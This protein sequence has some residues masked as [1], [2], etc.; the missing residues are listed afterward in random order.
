MCNMS[1]CTRFVLAFLFGIWSVSGVLAICQKVQTNVKSTRGLIA[2]TTVPFHTI[3]LPYG[4]CIERC[5]RTSSCT[6]MQ[7]D[8][9][10]SL[11]QLYTQAVPTPGEGT[12]QIVSMAD[13]SP[14]FPACTCAPGH[15]CVETSVGQ[16]CI[17]LK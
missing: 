7:F 15:M 16:Q 14:A 4:Q 8:E 3:T 11:C 6:F 2:N 5:W 12:R 17:R 13:F 1:G 9:S 10:T